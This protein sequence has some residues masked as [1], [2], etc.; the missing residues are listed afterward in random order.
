MKNITQVINNNKYKIILGLIVGFYIVLFSHLSIRKYLTLQSHYFDLGIMNQVVYNTAHGR[1]LEMTNQDFLKNV[2][3]FAIHF[4]PILAL[5]A[6]LYLIYS[7][8]ETLLFA[9]AIILGLGAAA[10]YL[11]AGY[12]LKNKPVSL[13]FS[14]A[15]LLYFCV[16]RANVFDFHGVTLGTTFILYMIY[17]SLVK[18]YRTA[19]VFMF[20]ALLTKEHAGLI[21]LFFGLYLFFVRKERKFSLLVCAL[22][23]IFFTATVNFVIPYFRQSS[24]FALKYFGDFGDSPGNI[25]LGITRNPL[26]V[27]NIVSKPDV[28]TY[29]GRLVLAN[30]IFMIFAPLEFLV[31][32]PELAINVL[33][34]NPNMKGLY[35][36]Y[37]ALIVPFIFLSAI[38]GY[39]KITESRRLKKYRIIFFGAFI[40][41]TLL[42]AYLFNPLPLKFLKEPYFWAKIDANKLATIRQ[43]QDILRDDSIKVSST[44]ELAPFFTGRSYYYNFLYDPSFSAYGISR[45]DII[46]GLR[47]YEMA[48]YV[49]IFKTGIDKSG[50]KSLPRRFYDDLTGNKRF[51]KIFGEENGIEVFKKND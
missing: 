15:Y 36:H 11:I 21:T 7:G 41:T 5:F 12:F 29:L 34:N 44:P 17:F 14:V 1:F 24:H 9:Q 40:A 4:D 49:V 37:N 10:V 27:I 28:L 31:S 26:L 35:F 18:K 38:A 30:G 45:D 20:L 25:F 2:S 50:K 8:P 42:S 16:E 51:Q 33:S 47:N 23:L 43:W 6:P 48:D 22:S 13:F 32:L 3:R 19:V 39:R 46:K